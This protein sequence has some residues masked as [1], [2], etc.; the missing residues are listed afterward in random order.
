MD[1][2]REQELLN[3]INKLEKNKCDLKNTIDELENKNKRLKKNNCISSF[4]ILWQTFSFYIIWL[5]I[6]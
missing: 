5:Y 4:I 3:T 6:I 2:S 1:Y